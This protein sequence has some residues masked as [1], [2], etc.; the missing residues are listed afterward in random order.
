[1]RDMITNNMGGIQGVG[2]RQD[3][4]R[5]LSEISDAV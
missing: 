2:E 5:L 4:F 3:N 1:M